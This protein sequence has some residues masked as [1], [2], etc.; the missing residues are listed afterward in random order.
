M[1]F[2]FI[3]DADFLAY[4]VLQ[5]KMYN[6]S[7][8]MEDIRKKLSLNCKIGYKKIIG[9]EVFDP[10]VFIANNSDVRKLIYELIGTKKFNKIYESYNGVSKEIIAI[11][12]LIGAIKEDTELTE[13]KNDL[14]DKYMGA[15]K[16][17]YNIKFSSI[18][19]ILIDNDI[20]S[21]IQIFKNTEIFKKIYLE[22]EVYLIN[23]KK[24]WEE[25]KKLINNFLKKVLKIDFV[26]NLNAYI[27]H[28][29]TYTGY[30][31]G[32]DKIAWGHYLGIGDPS[33][34]LTYLVH[35]GLHCLLLY[36]KDETNDECKIKHSIIELISD[37]ELYSLLKGKSSL[38]EGHP[39][40]SK[41]KNF[42]YPYWLKYIGLDNFEI[43]QRL[44]KDSVGSNIF[45]N[46]ENN[47]I[48]NLNIQ[49]F[50]EFCTEKYKESLTENFEK[51]FKK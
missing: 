16:S 11:E 48:S 42:I 51:E 6:E 49:Q 24:Y 43:I 29:N 8:E 31:F 38:K 44:K 7:K 28:P 23:V 12:I 15:Y 33:Y 39:Y 47:D 37:Y 5:R 9:E 18:S 36:E 35:E 45:D 22:T 30:S 4:Q 1:N 34:N 26:L 2:N 3:L 46:E 10:A 19:N 40:L 27:S 17:I 32:N 25:N 50:I 14:W 21:I 20:R 41:Y 13:I